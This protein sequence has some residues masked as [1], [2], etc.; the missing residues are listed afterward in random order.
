MN[1]TRRNNYFRNE[2][3]FIASHREEKLCDNTCILD[4]GASCR[5]AKESVWFINI[6]LEVMD[7]YLA[8]KNSTIA[9]LG[10]GNVSAKTVVLL[11]D[12]PI[13][14][15]IENCTGEGA[16]RQS[17][18]MNVQ[19]LDAIK[20]ILYVRAWVKKV[21]FHHV[22]KAEVKAL[23]TAKLFSKHEI[24]RR[25]KVSEAIERRLKNKIESGEELSPKT[26]KKCDRKPI[27][28]PRSERSLKKLAL[29]TD[30]L[31]QK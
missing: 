4:S 30:L 23:M 8:D 3:V 12:E 17:G 9:S 31:P 2:H 22:R 24:P 10:T 6:S 19:Q 25:L 16:H 14:C 20:S 11:I 18:K 21:I 15:H 13:L 27:F 29:R 26:N 5:M 28:N 7:I 1:T